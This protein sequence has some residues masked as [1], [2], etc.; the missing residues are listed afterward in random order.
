MAMSAVGESDPRS[1]IVIVSV[2]L[3]LLFSVTLPV[4]HSTVVHMSESLNAT[5][6]G[7]AAFGSD[8]SGC[9]SAFLAAVFWVS[10]VDQSDRPTMRVYA[11]SPTQPFT[12]LPE[13][14]AMHTSALPSDD[15]TVVFAC[16]STRGSTPGSVTT[17][18]VPFTRASA[19]I[20][21]LGFH[22]VAFMMPKAMLATASSPSKGVTRPRM[23][24]ARR[25]GFARV[26]SSVLSRGS[27]FCT[28]ITHLF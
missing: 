6:S 14:S 15:V 27:L 24:H 21:V 19:V 17:Y 25:D 22:T 3:T 11:S 20:C 8:W 16:S 12:S 9:C 13:P 23:I 4:P 2:F 5:S 7:W 26:S 1:M 10:S 28:F 18:R